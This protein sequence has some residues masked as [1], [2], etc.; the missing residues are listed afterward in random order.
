MAQSASAVC[1]AK[2]GNGISYDRMIAG[3]SPASKCNLKHSAGRAAKSLPTFSPKREVC[4]S[5]HCGASTP[6]SVISTDTETE[7]SQC[8]IS[9]V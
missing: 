8:L 5:L 4:L 6:V 3:A 9:Q 7:P 2:S 1:F